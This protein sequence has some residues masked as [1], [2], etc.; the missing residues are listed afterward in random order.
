[1]F[2]PQNYNNNKSREEGND[3]HL[4]N[5]VGKSRVERRRDDCTLNWI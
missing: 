3:G 2:N 4:G 1:V 5:Q